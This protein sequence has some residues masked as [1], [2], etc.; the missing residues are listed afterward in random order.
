LLRPLVLD[1][2]IWFIWILPNSAL[3]AH[4]PLGVIFVKK[5]LPVD[6]ILGSKRTVNGCTIPKHLISLHHVVSG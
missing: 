4:R 2:R 3:Q 1:L 6:P 5:N